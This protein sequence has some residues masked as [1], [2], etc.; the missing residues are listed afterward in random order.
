M[1]AALELSGD[2]GQDLFSLGYR[3]QSAKDRADTERRPR[4]ACGRH[5]VSFLHCRKT[6]PRGKWF[7]DRSTELEINYE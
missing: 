4:S 3:Q 6:G 7:K 2:F 5:T 1:H